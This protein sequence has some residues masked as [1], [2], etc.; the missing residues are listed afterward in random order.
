MN[1]FSKIVGATAL[2]TAFSFGAVQA[3]DVSAKTYTAT[4]TPYYKYSGYTSSNSDFVLDKDFIAA[5]KANNVTINGYKV[6]AK[7]IIQGASKT[8]DTKRVYDQEYSFF[9]KGDKRPYTASLSVKAKS[10]KLTDVKK[11]YGTPHL[12]QPKLVAGATKAVPSKKDGVYIY[13]YNG[14]QIQFVVEKGYVQKVVLGH[15]GMA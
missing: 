9:K 6:D 14:S 2:A 5:V 12:F 4:Q 7:R 1:K 8:H 10:L 3:D 15:V 13:N 11:T